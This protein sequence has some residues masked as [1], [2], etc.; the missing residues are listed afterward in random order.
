MVEEFYSSWSLLGIKLKAPVDDFFA[1]L[2]HLTFIGQTVLL[3]FPENLG[4]I[5]AIIESFT[6]KALIEGHSKCPDLCL[7]AVLVVQKGLGSHVGG[8]ADVVLKTGFGVASN[9]AVTEINDFSL[10]VVE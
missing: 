10:P 5:F 7:L 2:S 6:V 8:G 1:L 9:L 4:H 3:N